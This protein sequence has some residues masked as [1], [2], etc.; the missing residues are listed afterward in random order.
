M[1]KCWNMEYTSVA[2]L[3]IEIV[4]KVEEE[5]ERL[6]S[7]KDS[8]IMEMEEFKNRVKECREYLARCKLDFDGDT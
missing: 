7:M 4:S 5:V 8:K 6:E 3:K 2:D 1:Q